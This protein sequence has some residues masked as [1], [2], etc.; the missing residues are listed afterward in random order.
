M[1]ILCD[2]AFLILLFL[3]GILLLFVLSEK[4]KLQINTLEKVLFG[5]ILWNYFFIAPSVLLGFVADFIN[6]YFTI[7]NLISVLVIIASLIIII[8]KQKP[9]FQTKINLDKLVAVYVVGFGCF[10]VLIFLVIL[11]HNI[12]VEWDAVYCYIPSAKAIGLSGRITTNPYRMLDFFDVSP[13]MPIVYAWML[14]NSDI[15]SLYVLPLGFFALTVIAFSLISN[16]IFPRNFAWIS[17]LIFVSLPAV[18]MT[19]SSRGLYLD[20]AFLLYTFTALYAGMNLLSEGSQSRLFKFECIMLILSSTLMLLTKSDFG[21]LLAPAAFAILISVPKWKHWKIVSALLIGSPYYLREIGNISK[22]GASWIC[23]AQ[24]LVPIILMSTLFLVILK[25]SFRKNTESKML[26]KKLVLVSCILVLPAIG[27]LVR[28]I[29]VSGFIFP[30]YLLWN[31]E[32]ATSLTFFNRI[33]PSPTRSFNELMQWHNLVSVWWFIT[34]YIVL[35][36]IA[37]ISIIH[38]FIKKKKINPQN[39]SLFLFF[40]GI[41]ILW[42]Q[43]GCDP[44]PR[45]L[46]YLTPFAALTI[47]YGLYKIRKFYDSQILTLRAIMYII[48]ITLIIWMRNGIKTVNDLALLYGALYKHNIQI[49][50]LVISI[51]IFLIIFAPYELLIARINQKITVSKKTTTAIF[52]SFLLL[53]IALFSILATPMIVDVAN[54]GFQLRYKRYSGWYYYP[55]VIDYYNENITDEYT[56]LGFYCN[57]LITFANRTV[58]DLYIPLYGSPIY[59]IIEKANSTQIL[60]VFRKLHVGYFLKP[61][62]NNPFYATYEKLMNSTVLCNIFLDNP[63]FRALKTFKYATLYEFCENYT[64]HPLTYLQ[65]R[66]WNYNPEK[67][68][69]LTLEQNST[70]FCGTTT[71]GGRISLMYVLESPSNISDAL[72]LNIRSYKKAQLIVA[73]FSNLQNRTTDFFAFRCQL[74]NETRK[75]IININEGSIKG[76]FN[77]NHIEG[78]LIGIETE[79]YCKETFEISGL[80]LIAYENI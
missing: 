6:S 65:I 45:R 60:E 72:W 43:L 16:K 18:I 32:I 76:K 4:T 23:Y 61:T 5:S 35:F 64:I 51:V 37:I 75:P 48:A 69:T 68:I 57:E 36:S 63:Q 13:A 19:I 71:S 53:N 54:N 73:L 78:I 26:S 22:D 15:G 3:P 10:I 59:S 44:Q 66:P 12:F 62:S 77:P 21:L 8:K 49:E 1:C 7:F 31:N 47:T 79:P 24:R 50:L 67:N 28:N 70:K 39:I 33:R 27:Y 80:Y 58:I 9:K 17:P 55:D 46:Y 20:M 38:F 41:F 29:I 25:F 11:F 2:F 56:T 34:P 42:S 40:F 52:S 30:G 14:K 74:T